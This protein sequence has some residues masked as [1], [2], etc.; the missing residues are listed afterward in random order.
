MTLTK[1]P[2][3]LVTP[4]PLVGNTKAVHYTGDVT[5]GQTTITLAEDVSIPDD[6][7]VM[8]FLSGVFQDTV[9]S[10]KGNVITLSEPV[11]EDMTYSV[12]VSNT[13]MNTH[14]REK[15]S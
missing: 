10:I 5:E 11:P 4:E 15:T 3:E 6:A 8:V 14:V 13:F 12:V 7:M 9:Q 2:V 1:V